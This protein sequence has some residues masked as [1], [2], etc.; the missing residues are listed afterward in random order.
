MVLTDKSRIKILQHNQAA[1]IIR[2][3]GLTMLFFI[4][5]CHVCMYTNVIMNAILRK[6]AYYRVIIL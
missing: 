6:C 4:A 5:E 2:M 3:I 1:A